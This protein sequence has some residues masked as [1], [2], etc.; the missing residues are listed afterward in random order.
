MEENNSESQS[1][2]QTN[3]V[4]KESVRQWLLWLLIAATVLLLAASGYLWWLLQEANKVEDDLRRVN[5]SL[6]KRIDQLEAETKQDSSAESDDQAC[7]DTPTQELKDNI[8]AAL[9]TEN[10]AVFETYVTDPVRYVLAASEYGGNV[11]PTE[12]ATSLEYT[13]E[14]T[15]PWDFNLPAATVAAWDAGFYIDHF[16]SNTYVGR[17]ASGMVVAFDFDCDGKIK[18]IFVAADEDIL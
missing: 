10:T 12:A 8:K 14:A 4:K 9:D 18:Q 1:S 15:G 3:S 17:A 6:L 5:T 11:S 13:H 2:K 7:N 16:D